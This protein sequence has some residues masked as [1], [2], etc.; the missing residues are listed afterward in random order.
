MAAEKVL[1]P[2]EIKILRYIARKGLLA[3]E[4]QIA[5]ELRLNH[6]TLN[7]VLRK[8]E[9]EHVILGYK[10]RLDFRQVNL[11]QLAWVFISL[12][13][14]SLDV[15][16]SFIPR[17]FKRSTVRIAFIITGDYDLAFKMHAR[18][19]EEIMQ[20]MLGTQ[21]DLNQWINSASIFFVNKSFK[22]HAV[23]L[24]PIEKPCKLSKLDFQI[25]NA[26]LTDSNLSL[27][28]L[29]AKLKVHRNTVSSRWNRLLKERVVIKKTAT[30][31]PE[32]YRLAGVDFQV[33]LFLDAIPGK[34]EEL[35]RKLAS[36]EEIHEVN[37]IS[38]P[39]DLLATVK[40]RD[41]NEYFDFINQFYKQP[42]FNQLISHTKSCIILKGKPR[43][44][45]YLY[46][47]NGLQA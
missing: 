35:A 42:E 19:T 23:E 40:V 7:Y 26:R 29:A 46:E 1:T 20:F 28:D 43:P 37:L 9:R 24:K 30:I 14:N 22:Q 45:A 47:P 6:S 21:K 34:Q 10:Y 13:L 4:R 11:K 3:S 17:L 31:N 18:D 36:I 44:G 38:A 16:G 41:V 5:R 15:E 39:H 33:M 8:F 27:S 25:L 12:K 32:Y 2:V